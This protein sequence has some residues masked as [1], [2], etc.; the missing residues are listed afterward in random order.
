MTMWVVRVGLGYLLAIPLK[1]GIQGVWIGMCVEWAIKTLAFWHRFH[2]D[3]WL[4][5]EQRL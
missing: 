4:P 1:L 3:K 5:R 2:G